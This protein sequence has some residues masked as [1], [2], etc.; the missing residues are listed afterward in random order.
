MAN[1][2]TGNV[3]GRN[4]D[5]RIIISAPF[6]N[7]WHPDYTMA[8]L[9]TFTLRSRT[10]RWRQIFKTVRHA[11]GGW[12]NQIGLRNPGIA[13]LF[14][15][16]QSQHFY[17]ARNKIISIHGFDTEE[18][19]KLIN[20]LSAFLVSTQLVELNVSCPNV[21]DEKVDYQGIF[22][23]ARR[24]FPNV[25]VKIPPIRFENI[26]EGVMN[27]G[28]KNVHACNSY[29]TPVGG[30]SG[31][32]L[33][34]ITQAVIKE[35]RSTYGTDLVIIGGGGIHEGG[36]IHEYA[37]AGADYFAIGTGMFN[38][39]NRWRIPRLWTRHARSHITHRQL[40][41]DLT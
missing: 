30:I 38:P 16:Y 39:M 24:T 41:H 31:K 8:T 26:M 20:I 27:A 34:K 23:L 7:H 1:L 32:P 14:K 22:A 12:I 19:V 35:I 18:W 6:G 36:D 2:Y 17:N 25:I 37:D 9:G 11:N 10:G 15:D 28:V 13:S 21:A 33:R 4:P 5:P 29:P 40:R 3:I